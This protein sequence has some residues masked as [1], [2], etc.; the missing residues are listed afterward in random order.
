MTLSELSYSGLVNELVTNQSSW[1]QMTELPRK[2]STR[3]FVA[4]HVL[5]R[6]F[7]FVP[8]DFCVERW[9]FCSN[10]TSTPPNTG[11]SFAHPLLPQPKSPLQTCTP[12]VAKSSPGRT[13][14]TQSSP[15]R[16][17][18]LTPLLHRLNSTLLRMSNRPHDR[19]F[20]RLVVQ[21]DVHFP[22]HLSL[23]CVLLDDERWTLDG[24]DSG[25]DGGGGGDNKDRP[26]GGD[27][28]GGGG[29]VDPGHELITGAE[30]CPPRA[31]TWLTVHTITNHGES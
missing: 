5:R 31:R 10:N 7:P 26:P 9:N 27:G 2:S 18:P 15:G 11:S 4:T 23:V 24:G 16:T 17:S 19:A 20:S 3:V 13:N 28:R 22:P 25:G 14:S 12:P 6:V 8:S 30:P 21:R 29:G 1:R